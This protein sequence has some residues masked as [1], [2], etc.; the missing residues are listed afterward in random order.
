[1]KNALTNLA[2]GIAAVLTTVFVVAIYAIVLTRGS[3]L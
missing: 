2:K 1:V 3:Y